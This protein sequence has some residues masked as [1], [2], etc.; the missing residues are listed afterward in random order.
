[1]NTI[2]VC[3]KAKV[4]HAEVLSVMA[5]VCYLQAASSGNVNAGDSQDA[6]V[7]SDE[8]VSMLM[9]G[10]ALENLEILENTEG[11]FNADA[12]VLVECKMYSKSVP[13]L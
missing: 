7:G 10:S 6:A 8:P 12:S 3:L 5:F 2:L 11:G 1:M 9:N 4:C 13:G